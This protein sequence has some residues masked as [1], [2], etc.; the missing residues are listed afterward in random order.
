MEAETCLR[1]SKKPSSTFDLIL[2]MRHEACR[3]WSKTDA[4]FV[5]LSSSYWGGYCDS[6]AQ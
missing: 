6:R 3:N 4:T 2:F 1:N 5:V